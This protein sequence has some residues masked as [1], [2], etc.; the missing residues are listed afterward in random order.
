FDE[1]LLDPERPFIEVI[2]KT[3]SDWFNF[4]ILFMFNQPKFDQSEFDQA[5]LYQTKFDRTGFYQAELIRKELINSK[6]LGPEFSEKLH[7]KAY[8]TSRPLSSFIS[9]CSSIGSSSKG[10]NNK[11][12]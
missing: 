5:E 8:Y 2:H 7:P 4:F 3:F 10:K 9:K 12:S 1:K 11:K 6:K